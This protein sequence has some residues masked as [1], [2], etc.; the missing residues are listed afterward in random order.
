VTTI[1]DVAAKAGVSKATVSRV[2]SRPEAVRPET[3]ERVLATARELS[4]RPSHIARSLA[5]GRTG[6][7]GLVVPDV[8]N[9]YFGPVIKAVQREARRQELT[10]L[11][12]DSDEFDADEFAVSASLARRAD[13]LL[14]FSPRMPEAAIVELAQRL[15]VVVINRDIPGVP[16]VIISADEGMEQAVEHLTALGHRHVAFVGGPQGSFSNQ[17]RTGAVRA[18]CRTF[19]IRL[20]ELGTFE[21]FVRSGVRAGDLVI[22]SGATATITYNDLLALG[23]MQLLTERGKKVGADISVIGYDDIWLAPMT[24]PPLTTVR[25][26]AAEAATT[27]LNWLTEAMRGDHPSAD[28]RV[29]LPC[30]LIVRASTGPALD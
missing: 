3:R 10:V 4:F 19:G 8:A 9:P 23:V 16:A 30:E 29:L 7:I 2:F 17:A 14:L 26:P 22:A 21:P 18:A 12:A 20:S 1:A 11:I 27:A 28:R 6:S 15:P 13:G 5:I 24:Q 25:A